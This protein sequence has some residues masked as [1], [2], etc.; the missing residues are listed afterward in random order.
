M[1]KVIVL[2]VTVSGVITIIKAY[3]GNG[4]IDRAW[5]EAENYIPGIGV[6]GDT[7]ARKGKIEVSIEEADLE[8][9]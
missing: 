3:G 9:V 2:I 7:Y 4:A 8:E 5:K 6:S 1:S